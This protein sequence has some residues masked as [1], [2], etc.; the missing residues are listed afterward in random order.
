MFKLNSNL[1]ETVAKKTGKIKSDFKDNTVLLREL[2]NSR[3][4]MTMAGT[5]SL[6]QY[7]LEWFKQVWR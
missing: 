3:S 4:N 2:F 7:I 6:F 5:R 1:H